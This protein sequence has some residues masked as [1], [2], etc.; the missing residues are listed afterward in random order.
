MGLLSGLAGGKVVACAVAILA[1][2]NLAWWGY[3]SHLA[4]QR[5]VAV[6]NA[7]TADK[8]LEGMVVSRDAWKNKVQELEVANL[9]TRTTI[10]Y[11]QEALTQAQGERRR[12]EAEGQRAIAEARARAQDAELAHKSFVDRYAQQIRNPDCAGALTVLQTSCPALE[13]Y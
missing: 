1:A 7:G 11:L 4:G 6:A 10:T 9:A 12:L 13:G 5:D 3:A 2:G 8:A